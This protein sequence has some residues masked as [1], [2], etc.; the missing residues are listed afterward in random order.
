MTTILETSELQRPKGSK[1]SSPTIVQDTGD[2]PRL[3]WEEE[4]SAILPVLHYTDV[5]DAVARANALNRAFTIVQKIYSGT[6]W[7]NK[8]LDLP[9]DV[10][11]S[12]AV[13]SQERLEEFKALDRM[14]ALPETF[15]LSL[16]ED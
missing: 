11:F 5:D 10:A 16:Q 1:A 8:H 3:V 12:G 9:L 7:V 6:V 14:D 13:M 2:A 15:F 4:F